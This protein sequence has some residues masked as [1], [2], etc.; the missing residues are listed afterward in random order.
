[1]ISHL[2][3]DA[4]KIII[5]IGGIEHVAGCFDVSVAFFKRRHFPIL[6]E[7]GNIT[8][9]RALNGDQNVI[10]VVVFQNKVDEGRII[11]YH[12]PDIAIPLL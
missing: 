7:H 3:K 5:V 11:T 10:S 4:Y 12:L 1:M 8:I 6:Y 2:K 9:M